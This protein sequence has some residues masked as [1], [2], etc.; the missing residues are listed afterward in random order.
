MEMEKGR[1]PLGIGHRWLDGVE[2]E[3]IRGLSRRSCGRRYDEQ[4]L[5][6]LI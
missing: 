3:L 2:A 4:I 1:L 5:D 6:A